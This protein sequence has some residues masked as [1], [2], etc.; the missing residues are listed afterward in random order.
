MG[1]L[2]NGTDKYY[3]TED[4]HAYIAQ[5]ILNALTVTKSGLLGDANND[6]KVSLVDAVLVLD[7]CIHAIVAD[8]I[9]V[10]VADVSGDG[11]VSLADAV[12]ILDYSIK[13]IDRFPAEISN[14]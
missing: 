5:Q 1:L 12:M 13:A 4:G 6:G 14:S 2:M 10:A 3:A 7:Y 9:N 11:K 8:R